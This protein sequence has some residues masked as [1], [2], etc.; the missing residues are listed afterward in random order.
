M[1]VPTI[2]MA[3]MFKPGWDCSRGISVCVYILD[4]EMRLALFGQAY[5]LSDKMFF[6]VHLLKWLLV[7]ALHISAL[8]CHNK[9]DMML[10]DNEHSITKNF[11]L[12]V[13]QGTWCPNGVL[14]FS[15]LSICDV[16]QSWWQ[17]R[18][19][20]CW[21]LRDGPI[22][23]SKQMV[24]LDKH[25]CDIRTQMLCNRTIHQRHNLEETR[26]L[27]DLV[28]FMMV[29]ITY[30]TSATSNQTCRAFIFN[31]KQSRVDFLT[32]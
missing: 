27:S 4:A 11:W 13:T 2:W 16:Y 23:T 10:I 18:C 15:L 1:C 14:E 8:D 28:Q 7:Y 26:H 17:W 29:V 25:C 22:I 30:W 19:D 5:K 9:D 21:A 32:L 24:M 3:Y 6:W 20:T 12:A 31:K